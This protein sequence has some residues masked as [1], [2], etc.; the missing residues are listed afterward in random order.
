MS[1]YIK[2]CVL[3]KA[4]QKENNKLR[5]NIASNADYYQENRKYIEIL[6]KNKDSYW[7]VNTERFKNREEEKRIEK[8]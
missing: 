5:A 8:A 7:K 6:K 2:I 4:T 3:I 1:L